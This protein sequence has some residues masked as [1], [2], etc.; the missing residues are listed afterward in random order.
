MDLNPVESG[1]CFCDFLCVSVKRCRSKRPVTVVFVFLCE[2]VLGCFLFFRLKIYFGE[3]CS[4]FLE[5]K[6]F[7]R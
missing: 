1:D 5:V 6:S 3:I 2:F 7:Y 4:V